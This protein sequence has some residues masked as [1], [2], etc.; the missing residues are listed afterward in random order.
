[1]SSRTGSTPRLSSES[2]PASWPTNIISKR[3]EAEMHRI[4]RLA[5]PWY[6]RKAHR[7]HGEGL[8]RHLGWC[9]HHVFAVSVWQWHRLAEPV[10]SGH[11]PNS[12][13]YKR[14]PDG[15]GRAFDA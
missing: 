12:W 3:R 13:H 4:R 8:L 9:A 6:A 15:V 10:S 5:A 14:F 1:T 7:L 2:W 11:A